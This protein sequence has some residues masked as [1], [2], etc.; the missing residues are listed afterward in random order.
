MSRLVELRILGFLLSLAVGGLVVAALL[1]SDVAEAWAIV[2][3][4]LAFLAVG[5]ALSRR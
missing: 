5:W 3:G 2:V 4:W 1:A